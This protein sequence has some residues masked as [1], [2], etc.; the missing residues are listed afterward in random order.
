MKRSLTVL[1]VL[2]VAIAAQAQV[3]ST[4]P[5]AQVKELDWFVGT[6]K[7]SGTMS[8]QGMEMAFSTEMTTSYFGQFLMTR[9]TIDYGMLKV[10]ETMMLGW[11]D[12]KGQYVSYCFTNMSPAPRIERGM[13][14]GNALTMVS[15]PWSIMGQSMVSRGRMEK[16]S[17]TK[18]KF[19]LEFKEGETWTKASE[20]EL[21]KG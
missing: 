12:A 15:E 9:S 17:D 6:W 2:A 16:L 11:D 10:E 18:A 20:M 3:P 8:M 14:E 21:T 19:T 4:E 7:G 1:A 13:R 5:P